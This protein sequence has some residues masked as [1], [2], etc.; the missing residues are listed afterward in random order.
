MFRSVAVVLALMIAAPQFAPYAE[1][2]TQKKSESKKKTEKKPKKK[3]EK[4]KS[5]N[6]GRSDYTPEE[7]AKMMQRGREV[8]RKEF[9]APST[10][11]RIDYK[12]LR[13]YCRM[14]GS[15]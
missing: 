4:K 3:T 13:V 14:P 12:S 5:A 7:R 11:Y 15:G 6:K 10:V 8:C 1:A 9:G 2:Q